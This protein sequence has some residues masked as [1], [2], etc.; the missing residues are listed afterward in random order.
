M[1]VS[2]WRHMAAAIDRKY[3]QGF[4]QQL[5]KDD[6]DD[7]KEGGDLLNEGYVEH[8]IHHAQMSHGARTGNMHYGNQLDL[9]ERLTDTAI[10][11]F[12]DLSQRWWKL[13]GLS[14]VDEVPD[15][16]E[17]KEE[18][19]EEEEESRVRRTSGHLSN[20]ARVLLVP[21]SQGTST[22][23]STSTTTPLTYRVNTAVPG[24]LLEVPVSQSTRK[25]SSS[26]S[27]SP[28]LALPS[29]SS[30]S[31]F[32]CTPLTSSSVPTVI[33]S[34]TAI[35]DIT[36][37][38]VADPSGRNPTLATKDVLSAR[39]ILPA[40]STHSHISSSSSSSSI[41][42]INHLLEAATPLGLP[43]MR[44]QAR[45]IPS[46][47]VLPASNGSAVIFTPHEVL[48]FNWSFSFDPSRP[49]STLGPEDAATPSAAVRS[50]V[51]DSPVISTS[52]RP[53]ISW[54]WSSSSCRQPASES[55]QV[56]SNDLPVS[57]PPNPSTPAPLP[58]TPSSMAPPSRPRA[59]LLL[60]RRAIPPTANSGRYHYGIF[61]DPSDHTSSPN[62]IDTD[63]NMP[64]PDQ[65]GMDDDVQPLAEAEKVLLASS[66]THHRPINASVESTSMGP[67]V[68]SSRF[69]LTN[70]PPLPVQISP[71]KSNRKRAAG[72]GSIEPISLARL[73]T[74]PRSV[75]SS[76]SRRTWNGTQIQQAMQRLF[77]DTNAWPR[78]EQQWQALLAMGRG[79]AQVVVVLPTGGGKSLLFLI[80]SFL[81]GSGV[82]V[83]VLPLVALRQDLVRRCQEFHISFTD[84]MPPQT[85]ANPLTPTTSLVLVSV[86][87]ACH[88]SFR[89][90]LA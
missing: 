79:D 9:S 49:S 86:E 88:G 23:A 63:D 73:S 11:L 16:Q 31:P 15:S 29:G 83:V 68:E 58:I 74:R 10:Q 81:P 76:S 26:S 75:T 6:S 4:G 13:S 51:D 42:A 67:P 48:P 77:R 20:A 34:S 52:P 82:T 1:N 47:A 61:P 85:W 65:C 38:P 45:T 17:K 54:N 66:R 72:T 56:R 87:H 35:A 19:E 89:T 22:S 7:E 41:P 18:E 5:T 40:I 71:L 53:T 39:G 28:A 64:F 55:A 59:H 12:Y 60:T 21:D 2:T 69:D 90:L 46:A 14:P 78:S 84:W 30:F 36:S 8:R 33:P 27:S 25:A 24:R 70:S 44:P 3:L 62:Q 57:A 32:S 37:S 43:S 50:S 80:P